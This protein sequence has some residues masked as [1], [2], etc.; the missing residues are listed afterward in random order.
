MASAAL[1]SPDSAGSCPLEISADQ[2]AHG[3]VSQALLTAAGLRVTL[4][5]FSAGQELSE[6]SSSARVLVQVIAGSCEFIIEGR[7]QLL[8]AG[9]L[10]H[11]P[12]TILH[13]VRAPEALTLLVV[14]ATPPI[15]GTLT[16]GQTKRLF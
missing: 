5:K 9:E 10:L 13:A 12:P 2:V 14:Q 8:R 11:V 16:L 7:P 6:H 4:F 3:I 15:A 1:L